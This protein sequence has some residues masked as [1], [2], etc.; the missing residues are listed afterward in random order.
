LRQNRKLR[1][2]QPQKEE[3]EDGQ[4]HSKIDDALI[5]LLSSES[6]QSQTK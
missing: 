5:A 4:D 2:E 1:E 6:V 3:E